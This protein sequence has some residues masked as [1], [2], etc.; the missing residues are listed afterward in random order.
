[1]GLILNQVDII[2]AKGSLGREI[3]T[4]MWDEPAA[5][6]ETGRLHN[7]ARSLFS[8]LVRLLVTCTVI[9]VGESALS[10]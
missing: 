2:V 1:M 9:Q 3:R 6:N 5:L 8:R 10:K 7:Y 4:G